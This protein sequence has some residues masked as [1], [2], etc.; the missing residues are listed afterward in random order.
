MN[1]LVCFHLSLS[2]L[3]LGGNNRKTSLV[4]SII[5]KVESIYSIVLEK[6]EA[7]KDLSSEFFKNDRAASLKNHFWAAAFVI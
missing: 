3:Y 6:L 1:M 4:K 5:N 2:Q 7:I